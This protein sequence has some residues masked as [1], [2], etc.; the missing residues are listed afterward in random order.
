MSIEMNYFSS[1]ACNTS[2]NAE[3]SI[4]YGDHMEYADRGGETSEVMVGQEKRVVLSGLLRV[5]RL[6]TAQREIRKELG[7]DCVTFAYSF[8]SGNTYGATAAARKGGRIIIPQ[9]VS[10]LT[11]DL[12]D[13]PWTKAG[14]IVYTVN[15]PI[16]QAPEIESGVGP[17]F[18]IHATIDDEEPLYLSKFGSTGPIILT[19]FEQSLRLYPAQTTGVVSDFKV[20]H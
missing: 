8:E 16:E 4:W 15:S 17:H 19:S 9:T 5:A 1:T 7:H 2:T 3:S 13:S 10:R 14:D 18:M 12:S 20:M 6:Y 11:N